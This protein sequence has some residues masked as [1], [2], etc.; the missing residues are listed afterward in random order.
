ME[1]DEAGLGNDLEAHEIPG[2]FLEEDHLFPAARTYGLHQA[3]PCG[4]LFL[5]RLR[6]GRERRGDQDGVV[7]GVLGETLCPV[8]LDYLG[9][10]H[11]EP[12]EVLSR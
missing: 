5:E 8:A 4:E 12:G 9:V 10:R 3:S 6:D 1:F 2:S 7:G 11:A